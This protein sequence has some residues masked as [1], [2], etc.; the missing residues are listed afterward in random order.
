MSSLSFFNVAEAAGSLAKM[1]FRDMEFVLILNFVMWLHKSCFF[2]K[3]D[4]AFLACRA[5]H[6]MPAVGVMKT[7]GC[8]FKRYNLR[9]GHQHFENKPKTKQGKFVNLFIYVHASNPYLFL[10]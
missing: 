1:K 2:T 7:R 5:K 3:V 8:L 10:A 9:R 6:L 4:F